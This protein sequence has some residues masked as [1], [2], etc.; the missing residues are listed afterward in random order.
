MAEQKNMHLLTLS[1]VTL[2]G[3]LKPVQCDSIRLTVSDNPEGKGGGSYGI[4]KGHVKALISLDAGP[5]TAYE[6]GAPILQAQAGNGFATVDQ[7]TV[8]VV[9]D[10]FKKI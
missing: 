5:L 10:T 9:V 2:T 1:V 6:N 8:T 4:R 7:D 3:A